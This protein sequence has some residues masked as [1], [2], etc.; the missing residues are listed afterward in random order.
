MKIATITRS[1]LAIALLAGTTS[2]SEQY[3]TYS[4]AEYVM[5]ADTL[6]TNMVLADD[7]AFKV[8]VASTV[9]RDYDRTFGVEIIDRGSN[10]IE[11]VH[12]RLKSNTITIPA[13]KL[14]T[15]VEVYGRYENFEDTDSLGFS[16]QLVMP[17]KLKW[18][19]GENS[20]RTKVVMYKSCPFDI[21]NFTGYCVLSSML[22]YNYP[23]FYNQSYQKLVKTRLHPTEP[24]TIILESCFYTGYDVT[25]KFHPEEPAKPTLTMD[26]DQ[27]FSDEESVFGQILGDNRI[28]GTHS[29]YYDNYFNSCQRFAVLWTHV[30]VED[31]GTSI[32][33]VG[34]FYNILEWVSDEEAERLKR[35]EGW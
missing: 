25:M 18:P 32:G 8:K 26:K 4:D 22:L 31:I 12:Y 16:L 13:G 19:L 10:A 34:H 14:A 17:D 15:D 11:G 5:F 23:G 27:V 28:L 9:T 2:C 3:T 35:E 30:Y 20:N 33:T 7:E 29:T 1:L 21:N 24:N 6:S